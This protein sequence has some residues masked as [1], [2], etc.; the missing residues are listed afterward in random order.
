M[1]LIGLG[2]QEL[3]MNAAGIPRV[4]QVVREVKLEDAERLVEELL[5]LPTAPEVATRLEAFMAERFPLI[6]GAPDI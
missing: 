1:V 2:F 5:Q 6:F 3:S 4:K